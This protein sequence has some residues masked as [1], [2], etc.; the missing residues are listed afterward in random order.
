MF[1]QRIGISLSALCT[2]RIIGRKVEV[3]AHV[4]EGSRVESRFGAKAGPVER[5]KAIICLKT[6]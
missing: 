6:V 2:R 1:E 5:L 3:K 4:Q